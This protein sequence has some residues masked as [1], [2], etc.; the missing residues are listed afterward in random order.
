MGRPSIAAV[1]AGTKLAVLVAPFIIALV[2]I[3]RLVDALGVPLLIL[4]IAVVVAI[5]FAANAANNRRRDRETAQE[6]QRQAEALDRRR[7]DLNRKYGDTE[8]INRIMAKRY[9]QGQTA[10]QLVDSLGSPEAVDRH[11][12]KTKKRE[13]W[14]YARTRRGGYATKI[15]LEN[16]IVVAW[17]DSTS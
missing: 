11:T 7:N 1:N 6:I 16:D 4:I 3:L 13:V 2:I 8:L 9:W 10:E 5:G 14:K 15:T 12:L 17:S